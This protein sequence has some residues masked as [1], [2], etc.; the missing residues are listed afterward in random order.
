MLEEVPAD[1]KLIIRA[2]LVQ[3]MDVSGPTKSDARTLYFVNGHAL[4]EDEL[5]ALSQNQLLT[6]WG[7]LNYTRS[8]ASTEAS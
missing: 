1:I 4:S 2:L 3:R 6:S 7:I 5:G 8:R